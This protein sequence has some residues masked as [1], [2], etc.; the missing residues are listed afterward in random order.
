MRAD[1]LRLAKQLDLPLVATNDLHYT[2][3]EDATRALGAALRAV[4]LDDGRPQPV[5]VR[6]RRVLPQDRRPRC[7]DLWRDCPEACDNTLRHR[8]AVRRASSREGGNLMPR[9]PV[10]DGESEQ[11]WFVKEVERGLHHR[12]PARHPGPRPPAGG[13]RDRRHRRDGLPGLLPGRRRLHQLG[14]G[15]RHPGRPGPWLRRRV[16]RGVRDADHRPRPAR[17]RPDLRA[18]PQP[19]PRLDARLRRRLRR[20]PSR[21]G[22]P[23]RHRQVRLGP[24]RPD[25]HLRH[26]QGQ[27][28][29]QGLG[30]GPRLPVRRGGAADQGHAA[31]GD[32]QGHL[33][34][35]DLRPAGQALQG[36]RRVPQAARDGPGGPGGRRR[37][38][39]GS[40]G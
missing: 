5:Q 24:G 30:P 27:A 14:Q 2:R 17:A 18:L 40:R 23:L 3:A 36:G 1:L 12:Y 19:R 6:R 7:G 26:D 32:G 10:P 31:V 25:R 35:R 21:R 33:A 16:D 39:S 37:P 28:G 29:A 13:V 22:D 34:G 4:R 15:A 38:R 9:F 8:R 20:A 11:S